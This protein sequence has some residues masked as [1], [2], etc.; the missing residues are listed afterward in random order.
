MELEECKAQFRK[1]KKGEFLTK[2]VVE[3]QEVLHEK[4]ANLRS[5]LDSKITEV[6]NLTCNLEKFREGCD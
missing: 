6:E 3:S 2:G 5:Q 1:G 4:L